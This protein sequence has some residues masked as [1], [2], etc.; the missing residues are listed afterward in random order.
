MDFVKP[1]YLSV[2]FS[3]NEPSQI[4]DEIRD[5][6]YDPEQHFPDNILGRSPIFQRAWR[7]EVLSRII[8]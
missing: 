8:R 4:T 1:V 3:N 2:R 6:R 5:V 7:N